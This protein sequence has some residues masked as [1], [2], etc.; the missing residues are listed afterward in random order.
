MKANPRIFFCVALIFLIQTGSTPL[1]EPAMFPLTVKDPLGNKIGSYQNSYAL[2]VAVE[3]YADPWLDR[4]GTLKNATAIKGILENLGFAVT[5]VNHPKAESLRKELVDFI[6]LYG[7]EPENRLL[8][9]FSG[10]CHNLVPRHGADEMEYLVPAGVPS[11]QEDLVDFRETSLSLFHLDI[12]AHNIKANHTLFLLDGCRTGSALALQEPQPAAGISEGAFNPVRQFIL[13]HESPESAADSP[14]GRKRLVDALKGEADF[15]ADGYVTAL[16]LAQY[17]R[18]DSQENNNR[19]ENLVL[20][21]LSGVAAQTGNFVF[22]LAIPTPQEKPLLMEKTTGRNPN[23]VSEKSSNGSAL[24][25]LATPALPKQTDP[26]RYSLSLLI[27][28]HPVLGSPTETL[29]AEELAEVKHEKMVFWPPDEAEGN[30]PPSIQEETFARLEDL[31]APGTVLRKGKLVGRQ[32]IGAANKLKTRWVTPD[33]GTAFDTWSGLIWM[34]KDFRNIEK[35]PPNNW[36]EAI[37]WPKKINAR[38]F[39]GYNDWRVPTIEEM[40]FI[41]SND[42]NRWVFNNKR[43]VGYPE[44]FENGGG[45]W[46]WS[47]EEKNAEEARAFGF[48]TGVVLAGK[49][50]SSRNLGSVRL[51]RYSRNKLSKVFNVK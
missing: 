2:V 19:K 49:A 17:L 31:E 25:S 47:V 14:G 43:K 26:P 21:T 38:H 29:L 39:A 51:V 37:A 7:Q 22:P 44:V 8:I 15:N 34:V 10:H 30:H 9:Y 40:K 46:Y 45:Y 33:D 36:G 1:V 35:R 5:Q 12:Y 50:K 4:P 6:N 16:E 32:Q 18:D 41:Y 3:D 27:T 28:K 48:Y 24:E 11:P 23:S 20:G 42:P 13:F